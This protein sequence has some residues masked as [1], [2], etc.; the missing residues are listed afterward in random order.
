MDSPWNPSD[1]FIRSV[2]TASTDFE[3]VAMREVCAVTNVPQCSNG[4]LCDCCN[5][6]M[7]VHNE[8]MF[9]KKMVGAV[10]VATAYRDPNVSFV[11]S[12]DRHLQVNAET[13]AKWFRCGIE[14]V[15]KTLK[16]TTQRGV[17]QAMHPLNR[18][19]C[20]DHL[21]LNRKRLHDMFYMD[22]LFLKVKSLA[23]YT[24]AKLITNGTFTRV[25]PSESKSSA[26]IAAALSEFI[27]DVGIPDTLVCDLASKQTGKN[28]EVMRLIRQMHIKTRMTEK[29]RGITQNHRAETEIREVKTKWKA[30]MRN[31]Q[32]PT[33]LWDYGLVYIAEIQSL[34][35]RGVDQRPGIEK[36]TGHTIDISEWLDF[37]FFHRVWYWIRKRW[38]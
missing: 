24:C 14:T 25:S 29:G 34:L 33:R 20:F 26:N 10:R 8:S 3:N 12:K 17:R 19:Y 31:S 32:V 1:V 6:V 22:T 35:A 18:R 4:K 2:S 15:L 28:T 37:D 16:A 9:I 38:T 27:D 11:C 36:V 23:G 21:N 7:S 30:R 13:V 5:S